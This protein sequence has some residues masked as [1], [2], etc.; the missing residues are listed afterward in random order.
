MKVFVHKI[1]FTA[2][3]KDCI[4][5]NI[6][7]SLK[8]CE[9]LNP[10]IASDFGDVGVGNELIFDAQEISFKSIIEHMQAFKEQ[11]CLFKIQPK[12]CSYIIG[13]SSADTKGE[14]IQF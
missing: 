1:N 2:R 8:L 13:S 4:I 6:P 9:K 11:H 10:K 12:N 3:Y 14:V 7:E 5:Y